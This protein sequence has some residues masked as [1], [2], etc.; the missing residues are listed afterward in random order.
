MG[1]LRHRVRR[2]GRAD[3]RPSSASP[4]AGPTSTGSGSGHTHALQ[5]PIFDRFVPPADHDTFESWSDATQAYQAMVVRRQVEALRRIKYPPTGGFAQ[6]CFADGHPAITWSVLGHDRA[7]KLGYDALR[8]ACAPVIVVADRPGERS[9]RA[10]SLELDVHVVSDLRVP[11]RRRGGRGHASR[12]PGW[13]AHLAVERR[14]RGR[15]RA[16]GS[17]RS[18]CAVPDAPGRSRRA[19]CRYGDER[20]DNRYDATISG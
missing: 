16:S 5:K 14:P 18:P 9:A 17:A 20:V 1:A 2:A 4:S 8:A 15:R 3:R 10:T 11:H 19:H 6:F 12:W 7:P 13:R